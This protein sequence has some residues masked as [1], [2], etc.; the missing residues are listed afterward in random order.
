MSPRLHLF[1]TRRDRD[2]AV[3]RIMAA[4]VD[5][6]QPRPVGRQER[7]GGQSLS[8][9]AVLPPGRI[10]AP[11][12]RPGWDASTQRSE[13]DGLLPFERLLLVSVAV[14]TVLIIAGYLLR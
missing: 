7:N 1:V 9:A 11:V 5:A 2:E 13:S 8:P 12:Y 4:I 6:Y 14:V 3:D 10:G